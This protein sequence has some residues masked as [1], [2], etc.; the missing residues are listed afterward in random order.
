MNTNELNT[1]KIS[2]LKKAVIKKSSKKQAV[3]EELEN[4]IKLQNHF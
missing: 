1:V 4:G 2:Q 3:S